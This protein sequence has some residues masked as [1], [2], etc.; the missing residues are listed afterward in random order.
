MRLSIQLLLCLFCSFSIFGQGNWS[1]NEKA[2]YTLIDKYNLAREKQDSLLL[3]SILTPDIDQLVST[4][5]WRIGVKTALTGMMQS[6]AANSGSRKI[7]VDKVKF[8][9]NSAAIV[10]AR[11]EITN[12]D[13]SIRKMW[14]TFVVVKNKGFWKISAIRNMLPTKP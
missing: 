13:G 6:S 9:N 2:I 4:G 8:L 11:Y 7:I 3:K 12:A 5:E 10:D 1:T 14:S